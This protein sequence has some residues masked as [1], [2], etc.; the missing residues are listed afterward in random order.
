MP[1][2]FAP[3][4]RLWEKNP[5]SLA[6][7][8]ACIGKWKPLANE[9]ASVSV[10]SLTSEMQGHKAV[11]GSVTVHVEPPLKPSQALHGCTWTWTWGIICWQFSCPNC[12]PVHKWPTQSFNINCKCLVNSS[13][14]LLVIFYTYIN[15]YFLSALC[16]MAHGLFPK[17]PH[18]LLPQCLDGHLT[19][20]CPS[21]SQHP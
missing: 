2:Y 6:H 15:L 8:V 9:A 20:L 10:L 16:H 17:F 12:P 5:W 1:L 18:A 3:C 4:E 13:G 19:W 21:S 14:L 7:G 11:L